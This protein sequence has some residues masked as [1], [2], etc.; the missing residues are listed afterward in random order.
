MFNIEG[1]YFIHKARPYWNT[2]G[3][4]SADTQDK[5]YREGNNLNREEFKSKESEKESSEDCRGLL[6]YKY[7][8]ECCKWHKVK[9]LK[10]FIGEGKLC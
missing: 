8:C 3:V 2:G 9:F 4:M 10:L 1:P 6:C 7:P 5:E